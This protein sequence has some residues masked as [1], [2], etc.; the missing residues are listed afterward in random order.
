MKHTE[1][2]IIALAK[3]CG[4]TEVQH[5]V[6]S[7]VDH[8][9]ITL[10]RTWDFKI[11]QLQ[12]FTILT[13]AQPVQT[14]NEVALRSALGAML[15][16]MGMDEDCWNKPTFDQARAALAQLVQPV[17]VYELAAIVDSTCG[18]NIAVQ[19]VTTSIALRNGTGSMYVPRFLHTY[20]AQCDKDLGP[21]SDGVVSCD[22]HAPVKKEN[23]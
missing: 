14:A 8:T 1:A 16:H 23:L 18:S 15:T 7:L 9:W 4:A 10:P 19:V 21:G 11:D 3:Q 22:R 6:R 2:E 20:C 17:P 12:A 13:A 5:G